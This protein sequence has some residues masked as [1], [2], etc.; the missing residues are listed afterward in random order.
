MKSVMLSIKPKYCELIASGKKTIEVRKT[1]PKIDT[2]FKCYIYCTIG[3]RKPNWYGD[4]TE[5]LYEPLYLLR[6]GIVVNK[7]NETMDTYN[8]R[9]LNGAVIGAFIC[10]KIDRIVHGGTS[11]ENIRLCFFDY[12]WTHRPLSNEY[13]YQ[14]QLSYAELDKYSNGGNLYGW[15]ISDLKIYAEPKRLSEFCYPCKANKNIVDED[16]KG[17]KYAFKGITQGKISCD[18]TLTHPFQSWGYVE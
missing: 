8:M 2:P 13:L 14:T 18:K 3:K 1:R 10:D 11:N 7:I 9:K 16:C 15:H 4:L 12:D 6:N 5:A 17:C